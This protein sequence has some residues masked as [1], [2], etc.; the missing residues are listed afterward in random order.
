MPSSKL[1]ISEL[2]FDLIKRNLKTFL[3]SQSEFQDYNFEGSGLSILLDTLSYNTHYMSY[4]ANMATNEV[5]LDS[6]DIRKNIVSIARMLGYTPSSS[7]SPV[8]VCD[9]T[10]NNASG[11]T[12]TLNKGTI[13]KS[14]IG[15]IGYQFVVNDDITITPVSGVYKFS[16]VSLYE[17]TLVEYK[18]TVDNND[19]DQKFIIPSDKADT[20]TLKVIVQ[21]SSQ[22]NSR[23]TYTYSKD[24]ADVDNDSEVFF[25]QE[26][27]TGRFQVYFGDGIIGKK[28]DDGN[29][30]ILQYIVTNE[31]K[32]NGASAFTLEGNIGGFTN[33]V[34]KSI[35][36][37][38]GGNKPETND[39]I[40][41]NAP[42][43]Y[44][45]QNRAVT[46]TD[47]E[48]LVRSI[49]PN[50]LSVSS[51]GGEDEE[52]PI[53]G[54]V[55]IS[56]KPTSGSTLTNATKQ[57]IINKLKEFN[58]ASVRPEIVDPEITYVILSSTVNYDTKLTAKSKE[59]IGSEV[60]T[61]IQ[62]YNLNTLQRFDGVFRFSKLSS[63][64]D[65]VDNSIVSNISTIK[66]RKMLKPTIGSSTKYDLYFRNKFYHPHAGHQA[67][68]GGILT[69]SGFF[70]DG[71]ANEM[72]LDEDGSGNIRRYYVSSGIKQI[73]NPTQGT[74]D[75][76]TGTVSI[77][78]LTISSVSNIR[79]SAS[80]N[81]EITVEPDSKDIVPV[82]NQVIEIDES[83]LSIVVSP[84]AFVGGSAT[85]GVGYIP[86]SSY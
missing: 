38:Q 23:T 12:L 14:K 30:V 67:A 59:T 84:D 15:E 21:K 62:N 53:Y 70:V 6:A 1:D 71:N 49:Y 69:S 82:R 18:Y 65:N 33:V 81:I 17:G 29:I 40:R 54:V 50:T 85:A 13:F 48:T 39:S 34:V 27:D 32:A 78:S 55:K 46:S 79:G 73:I 60:T 57:T 83:V 68:M 76:D 52:T 86:A 26:T 28:P 37:A 16:N 24:Y 11:T 31:D 8:A 43:D 47:Y 19:T 72:F 36:S 74:I 22:D 7:K 41:F 42:F 9:I 10:V 80:T 58:V 64:I 61:A 45:R 56:I 75:Y 66:I 5:Y 4:L 51:W 35:S 44:A 20:D 77:N 63:I 2:D 3:Q 25:L